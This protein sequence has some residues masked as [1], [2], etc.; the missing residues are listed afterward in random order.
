MITPTRM[1][2][3][4]FHERPAKVGDLLVQ[5][6]R[7]HRQAR[8]TIA[9]GADGVLLGHAAEADDHNARIRAEQYAAVAYGHTCLTAQ[10]ARMWSGAS[11]AEAE[12]LAVRYRRPAPAGQAKAAPWWVLI[13][14]ITGWGG[15]V[16]EIP[17][18]PA[19][20]PQTVLTALEQ[21]AARVSDALARA[22]EAS[23]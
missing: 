6:E 22:R 3:G 18:A 10:L 19:G 1:P 23:R 4:V 9:F 12:H 14:P 20:S 5:F 7:E 17:D 13:Q 16:T 8:H 2:P 21:C 11:A 15:L